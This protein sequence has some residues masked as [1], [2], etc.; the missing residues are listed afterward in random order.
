M[1]RLQRVL[2]RADPWADHAVDDVG[3]PHPERALIPPLEQ[4]QGDLC[5][6]VGQRDTTLELEWPATRLRA[7]GAR[8]IE[9]HHLQLDGLGS[10]GRPVRPS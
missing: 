6:G 2:E 7:E 5:V 4:V 8:R 3:G 1:Q 9:V 10:K